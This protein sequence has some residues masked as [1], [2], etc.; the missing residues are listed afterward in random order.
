MAFPTDRYRSG[1]LLL[2]GESGV[3]VESNAQRLVMV[4]SGTK[5]QKQLH[6]N[7]T[8]VTEGAEQ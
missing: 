5:P 1:H 7:I 3:T 4:A 8:C 2:D 6:L